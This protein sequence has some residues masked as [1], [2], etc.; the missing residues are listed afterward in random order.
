MTTQ[1]EKPEDC[2]DVSTVYPLGTMTIPLG[3]VLFNFSMRFVKLFSIKAI[4][5]SNILIS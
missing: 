4:Y 1:E 5:L 3:V 2:K